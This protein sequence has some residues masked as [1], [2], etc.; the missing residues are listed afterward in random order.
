MR[1]RVA[2]AAAVVFVVAAFALPAGASAKTKTV[3]AGQ[4]PSTR[5]LARKLGITKAFGQKYA[6]G[7][8]AFFNQTVTINQGDSVKWVGL[9]AGFHTI[10]LPG[11]SGKDIALIIPVGAPGPVNDFAG[12]PFWFSG[13]APTLGFNPQLLAR[14]GGSTYD[15]SS[16]VDTGLAAGPKPSDSVK[17]TFTKPG[18]YKYF[19]DVHTG[20]VGYVVVRAKG[21][22]VPSAKQDAAALK[23]RLT[24]DLLAAKKLASTKIAANHVSLGLS[25]PAGVELFAMF[26]ATLTVKAGTV[27][28]FSMSL[29]SREVH[30]A[31]FG[32]KSYLKGLADSVASPN[33]DQQALF[34]SSDPAL[35]PIPLAPSSHGNGFANT[36]A[37]DRDPATTTLPPSGQ[38]KFTTPG[39]YHYVCLIH[40]FMHG[41]VIVK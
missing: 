6:P 8:N 4:P 15:G 34:P 35:G 21:K 28:T 18:R 24:T 10:D 27:V 41:T 23:Q 9:V 14:I 37:L 16:R 12:I 19:C 38:I 13:H 7:A 17:V 36:G 29:N 2:I 33:F 3:Y 1:A 40:P 31:A 32:T 22:A 11:S 20:M 5:A 30:T 26:P 25:S 39:T